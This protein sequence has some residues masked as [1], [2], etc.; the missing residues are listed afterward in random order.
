MNVIVTRHKAL[1][2]WLEKQGYICPGSYFRAI[3]VDPEAMLGNDIICTNLI[4]LPLM[5]L[6]NSV[7]IIPLSLTPED[8]ES[9]WLSYERIC[10]IAGDPVTY[11]VTLMDPLPLLPPP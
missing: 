9:P 8:R 1:V 5:A 2:R 6:A 7:T 4:S 3:H 10:E 11:K